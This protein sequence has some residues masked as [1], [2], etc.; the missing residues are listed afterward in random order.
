MSVF[1]ELNT[2]T[3]NGKPF[4]K[5]ILVDVN[6]I[7]VPIIE[8]E[9]NNSVIEVDTDVSYSESNFR[10]TDKYIVS[11]DLDAINALSSELFKGTI[12]SQ[13]GR[14]SLWPS[15]VFIKRS[16]VGIVTAV[17]DDDAEFDYGRMAQASTDK[18]IVS[19]SLAVINS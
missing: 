18:F 13:N 6:K 4:T 1:I 3:R 11:E 16:I 19:E 12:V 8:N 2:L 14:S 17:G 7:P 5:T 15:A 10:N 9:S